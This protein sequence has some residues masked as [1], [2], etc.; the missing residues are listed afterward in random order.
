MFEYLTF[1][2]A[3]ILFLV[4]GYICICAYAASYGFCKGVYYWRRDFEYFVDFMENNGIPESD[5]EAPKFCKCQH[6]IQ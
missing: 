2:N 3:I 1:T 4:P 5:V 6:T